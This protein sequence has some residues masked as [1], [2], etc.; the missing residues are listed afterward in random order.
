MTTSRTV[1]FDYAVSPAE[2][3]ALLQ[4]PVYLRYRS[5]QAGER[6]IDV[7]VE[8]GPNGTRVTVSRE[9]QVDVPAFA[10][11]AVGSANRATE[12]TLWRQS[13]DTWHAEYTIEVSGLPVKAAGRSTLSPSATGCHYSSTFESTARIPLIGGRIEALFAEGLVEQLNENANRNDAAL[14]RDAARGPRS[15]I[16]GLREGEKSAREG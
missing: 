15:F 13:G 6:N 10:R 1:T 2:V 11:I 7:K 16:D 9:K 4:D 8:P 5:E 3:A 12:S 14:K